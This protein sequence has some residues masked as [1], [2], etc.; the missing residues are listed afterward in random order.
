M[1]VLLIGGL[2][3]IGRH[4]ISTLA[5]SVDLSILSR[6]P[7]AD[8]MKFDASTGGSQPKLIVGDVTDIARMIEI[9]IKE[10]PDVVVH[11][12]ALTGLTKCQ[13]NQSNAFS[14]NVFGTY[15]VIMGCVAS[16]AKL[17]FVSSREVYGNAKSASED[18][19]LLPNNIY[20]VTKLLAE[21]LVLWAAERHGLDYT[22]LRLTNVYGP[23]GDQYNIQAMI[24]TALSSGVITI[25]GGEQQL[26]LVYVDD[27]AEIIKK[28]LSSP[29]T[30]RQIFN[31]GSRD[32]LTV[33]Q[34]VERL[35]SRMKIPLIIERK[36]MRH[37]ETLTCELNLGKI[38]RVLGK[39]PWTSFEDGL[40][41][42]LR[43]YQPAT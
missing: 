20:G 11:L 15:N 36:S 23:G 26:N 24:K 41:K 19:P 1:K 14:T 25:L 31:V 3:F 18:A 29:E 13:N 30:S 16:N 12:A 42:T 5:G 2:G 4:L 33:E 21:R 40:E 32:T 6:T 37:G 43:W 22:I 8:A 34:I 35:E 27:V 7:Q 38:E 17:I 28:C 39:F 10:G 9:I